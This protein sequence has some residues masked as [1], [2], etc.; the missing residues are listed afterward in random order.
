[1]AR[2]GLPQA[3]TGALQ[4]EKTMHKSATLAVFSTFAFAF[5]SAASLAAPPGPGMAPAPFKA[6]PLG[7]GAVKVG[8]SNGTVIAVG[9]GA[10]GPRIYKAFIDAAGGPDALILDVPNNSID[11]P[12]TEAPSWAGEGFRKNGAR[13][14]RVLFTQSRAVADSDAFV[15]IIKQAK[16]IWFD[17][18]RQYRDIEAY[19]G[20]QSERAFWGVLERG[21]VIGGSS[22]G[23]AVL[24][25]FMVRGAPSNNNYIEDYPGF[26]KGFGYLRGVA[27]DMHVV[28]RERLPDLTTVIARYPEVLGISADEG[29]AW[30]I[31]GDVGHIIGRDKA[32]V[33]NASGPTDKGVPYLTLYPGDSYNLYTRQVVGR[34]ADKS[35]VTS[36]FVTSLF[37]K[38]TAP[39]LGG[40][41]VL[42]AEDGDVLVDRAF[43][44]PP[45]DRYMPRTTLPQFPIGDI[46]KAFTSLCAQLPA[47]TP[48][49]RGVMR[50]A[51]YSSSLEKC[52]ARLSLPVGMHRTE[53]PPGDAEILSDVDELYRF[54]L[55]HEYPATWPNTDYSKG[56]IVDTYDGVQRVAAYG[57]KDGKRAALVRIPS[58]RATVIILANDPGADAR[59]MSERI[60]D[61]LLGSGR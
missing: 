31:H 38:Y 57:T 61:K 4:G 2:A 33:Y 35:P 54:E 24:G 41:T 43:G 53:V 46:G 11:K 45:Q 10:Q 15:A 58:R 23:M 44:V 6:E 49:P 50:P 34:A 37:K 26:E 22:A 20:T 29:T 42:V 1:M 56:W 30:V 18:G 47:K 55:G 13:N 39:R 60:L 27:A 17:G 5:T 59:A 3:R 21:G 40:A 12:A 32:F 19:A 7:S 52:V 36:Q 8:P 48:A 16:G 14:V 9:G 51:Y 28:A 25:D